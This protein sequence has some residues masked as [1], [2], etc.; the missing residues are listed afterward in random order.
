[1]NKAFSTSKLAKDKS[2]SSFYSKLLKKYNTMPYCNR[3]LDLSYESKQYIP[4]MNKL[5][6]KGVV[7]GYPPLH[8]KNGG[9]TAQ[10]EHT[11]YLGDNFGTPQKIIFSESTDY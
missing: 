11:I 8:C 7:T 5:V 2:L 10:Y 1:M 4:K 9:M 3:Y 6:E